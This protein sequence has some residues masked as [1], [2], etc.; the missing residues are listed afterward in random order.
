MRR[1]PLYHS[2]LF[3]FGVKNWK[4]WMCKLDGNVV[5]LDYIIARLRWL[6]GL[7][8]GDSEAKTTSLANFSYF[9]KCYLNDYWHKWPF[10]IRDSVWWVRHRFLLG[11][12]RDLKKVTSPSTA[13]NSTRLNIRYAVIVIWHTYVTLHGTLKLK[14]IAHSQHAD[15][16]RLVCPT[17]RIMHRF[18]KE[19]QTCFVLQ[20]LT[21]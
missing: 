20:D 2:G 11:F 18:N 1:H 6:V 12:Y 8:A 16:T 5:R 4:G 17:T 3:S 14:V 7:N 21:R 15:T 19:E 9:R 13:E 10:C